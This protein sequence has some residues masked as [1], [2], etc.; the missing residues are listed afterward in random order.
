MSKQKLKCRCIT[1]GEEFEA[2]ADYLIPGIEGYMSLAGGV[3]RI[4]DPTKTERRCD[5]C[6]SLLVEA[7]REASTEVGENDD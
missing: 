5:I 6:T 7:V 3:V 4:L 2:S 1:C